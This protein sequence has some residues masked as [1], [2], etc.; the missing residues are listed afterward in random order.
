MRVS[1][2]RVTTLFVATLS[3]SGCATRVPESARAFAVVAAGVVWRVEEGDIIKTKV[4]GSADLSAETPV[5]ANGTAFFPAIGRVMIAGL[6]LDSL[7]T[8]LNAK[9]ATQVVRNAAVQVTMLRDITIYGQVRSPGVY[10][11]DPSVTLVGLMARAGGQLSPTATVPDIY[12]ESNGKRLA[13]PREARLGSVDLHRRDAIF[14]DEQNYFAR[15]AAALQATS[16]ILN[17]I[18]VI[19]TLLSV[20]TR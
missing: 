4:Y 13:L 2:L 16:V 15:N 20:S 6:S 7:E 5:N 8:L 11:S 17:V 1:M 12:V 18:T 9:Y 14:L 10:P 3:L 19:V